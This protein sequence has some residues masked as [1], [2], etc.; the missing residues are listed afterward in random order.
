MS[1]TLSMRTTFLQNLVLTKG[2]KRLSAALIPH[3]AW[4]MYNI[5]KFFLNLQSVI[6]NQFLALDLKR[7]INDKMNELQNE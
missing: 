2:R 6:V 7:W 4:T 1:V 5:F 3:A